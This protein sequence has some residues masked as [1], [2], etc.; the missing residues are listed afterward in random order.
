MRSRSLRSSATLSWTPSLLDVGRTPTLSESIPLPG[1][2]ASRHAGLDVSTPDSDPQLCTRWPSLSLGTRP[3]P[4][5]CPHAGRRALDVATPRPDPRL[6]VAPASLR[7]PLSP[8]DQELAP[9]S[10]NSPRIPHGRRPPRRRGSPAHPD[11]SLLTRH[12]TT[13]Q[14]FS[15]SEG[16]PSWVTL[17]S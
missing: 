5:A 13:L 15:D 17:G 7:S 1:P 10:R 14:N 12:P 16:V 6:F 8:R 3:G 9:R 11:T 2:S 4:P